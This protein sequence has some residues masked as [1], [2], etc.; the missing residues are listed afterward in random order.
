MIDR[1]GQGKKFSSIFPVFFL[2]FFVAGLM[3]K[4]GGGSICYNVNFPLP[5]S[6]K[7]NGHFFKIIDQGTVGLYIIGIHHKIR[8]IVRTINRS[9]QEKSSYTDCCSCLSQYFSHIFMPPLILTFLLFSPCRAL[10]R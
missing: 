5:I 2:P 10:F 7:H 9:G 4:S 1:T 6:R 8:N 3:I